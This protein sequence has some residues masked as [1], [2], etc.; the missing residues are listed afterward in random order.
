MH[1]ERPRIFVVDDDEAF[2]RSL[3]RLL[4]SAGFDVETFDAQQFLQRDIY[5]GTSCLLLDVRMP[6]LTGLDLQQE[7]L[8]RNILIPIVFLTAHGDTRTGIE[9][10]KSGAVDYLLKPVDEESLF[11]AIERA[12]DQDERIK[13]E[14]AG[15]L[16]GT[17]LSCGGPS[18]PP[19]SARRSASRTAA[20]KL[21]MAPR[22][23][24][25]TSFPNGRYRIRTCDLLGVKNVRKYLI[26]V[27]FA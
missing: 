11:D 2:S 4:R 7:L 1:E 14:N 26:P 23:E 6:G 16:G 21:T 15:G 13:R 19:Q 17:E 18:G 12:L 27:I 20:R 9:A 24:P 8:K 3:A 22:L 25:V 10:M 5:T